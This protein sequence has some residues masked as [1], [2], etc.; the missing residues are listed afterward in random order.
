MKEKI[1]SFV[2]WLLIWGI[3]VYWY[4]YFTTSEQPTSNLGNRWNFTRWNFDP[5]NMTDEQLERMAERA[6]ITKEELKEK[7]DSWEDIR[8][9]MWGAWWGMRWNRTNMWTWTTNWWPTSPTN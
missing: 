6:W 9:L 3:I 7:I 1:I 4:W 5:A 8:S 2:A